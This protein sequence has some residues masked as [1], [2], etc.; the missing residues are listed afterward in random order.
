MCGGAVWI[1]SQCVLAVVYAQRS[2]HRLTVLRFGIIYVQ[3]SLHMLALPALALPVGWKRRAA[4]GR[5]ASAC[6]HLLC[7]LVVGILALTLESWFY[8][9]YSSGPARQR[10]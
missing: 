7:V 2:L 3:R 9:L 10:V 1:I 8:L 4:I 5:C 6:W